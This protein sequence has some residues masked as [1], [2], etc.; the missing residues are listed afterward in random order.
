[1]RIALVNDYE[2]VVAGLREMLAPHRERIEVVSPDDDGLDRI[3]IVLYDSYGQEHGALEAVRATLGPIAHDRVVL[4]TWRTTQQLSQAALAAGIDGVLSKTISA[5]ELASSLQL[6]NDGHRIFAAPQEGQPH[7][8]GPEVPSR[9]R[10]GSDWPGRE[11][12]LT[13]REA[14]MITL[15]SMGLSNAEIASR[16][17]LSPNSVK[18]YIRSAY[19]K[20]GV[21]R[22]SQAVAWGLDNAMVPD[23]E[24]RG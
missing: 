11:A 14:E 15:I 22:R 17:F 16:T 24:P 5:D 9:R 21:A 8:A 3:D 19:R 23:R 12:G 7:A 18:S 1:M 10:S 2:I 4:Y 20:I 6:I 13:M